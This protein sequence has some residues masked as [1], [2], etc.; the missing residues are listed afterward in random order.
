M[1]R[2]THEEDLGV[3]DGWLD[4]HRWP[5]VVSTTTVIGVRSPYLFPRKFERKLINLSKVYDVDIELKSF[6]GIL[7]RRA[8]IV[9]VCGPHENVKRYVRS[10]R[11]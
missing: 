5:G 10:A 1:S 8:Y 9:S 4:Q 2:R 7:R 6:F 3:G 11:G